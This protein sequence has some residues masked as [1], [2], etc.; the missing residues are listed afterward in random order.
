[1]VKVKRLE[2]NVYFGNFSQKGKINYNVY[3][4]L[5]ISGFLNSPSLLTIGQWSND[6]CFKNDT[7]SNSSQTVCECYHLTHFAI[8]L[9]P[10]PLN[11]ESSVVISLQTIGYIGVAVSLVAMAL[12]ISTFLVFRYVY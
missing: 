8:L 5:M 6:G 2:Q 1:M 9:S 3:Q 12:T 4:L 11:P 10:V 7:L